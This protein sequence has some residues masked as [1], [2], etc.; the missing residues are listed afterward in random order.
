MT[1]IINSIVG[2]S[3]VFL[4]TTLGSSFVFFL[5][6]KSITPKLNRIFMGFAAGIMLSASVF[7]LILPALETEAGYMPSYVIVAIAVLAGAAFLWGIDKLTPHI[8]AQT[9]EEEGLKTNRI[10][11]TS[12]M[13]LAVTIHN[14]PE[15]LSVGIAYGVALAAVASGASTAPALFTGAFMLALGIGIQNIPEGAVVALPIVGETG[16]KGKAFLFGTFSGAV[17]PIAAVAGLFLALFIQPIMP[18]ALAFAAGCMLYVI[19]EEMIPEIQSG[20]VSHEGVWS[21]MIGFV[22]MLVLDTALG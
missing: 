3:L 12:K 17:E 8:H 10:S 22:L 2:I 15:G 11:R 9:N 6:T 5:K 4:C 1:P 7:S 16:N 19:A 18:W 20:S 14:V 13:F 21:F